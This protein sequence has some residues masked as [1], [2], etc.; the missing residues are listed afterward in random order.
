MARVFNI[1]NKVDLS[2][3]APCIQLGDTFIFVKKCWK[4]VIKLQAYMK[5]LEEDGIEFGAECFPDI[6]E[7][8]LEPKERKK[9]DELK[10]SLV[11]YA[12]VINALMQ[13]ATGQKELDL[14]GEK[15]DDEA[16]N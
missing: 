11:D 6:E 13:A 14:D 15:N 3:E 2:N 4:D 10:L 8:L 7:I 1:T 5:Q 9:L 16:K 12:T